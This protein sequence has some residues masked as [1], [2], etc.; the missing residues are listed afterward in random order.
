MTDFVSSRDRTARRSWFWQALGE[1]GSVRAAAVL[2]ATLI[3][4]VLLAGW[5]ERAYGGEAV[6]VMIYQARWFDALFLLLAMCVTAAAVVRF[7]WK[8]QQYGFV[9]VHVGLVMLIAGFW[10]AGHDRLDGMLEAAPGQ[11]AHRID[12]PLDQLVVLDQVE[13]SG[14]PTWASFRFISLCGLPSLP[15]FSLAW[16]W[17]IDEPGIRTLPKPMPVVRVGNKVDINIVR[18]VETGGEELAWG[19]SQGNS[20]SPAVELHL[21]ARTPG[22]QAD[23]GNRWLT[24]DPRGESVFTQ[25][26]LGATLTRTSSTTLV[27]DFLNEDKETAANGRLFVYHQG[28]RKVMT[29]ETLPMTLDL[30]PEL[31]ITA[32]RIIVHPKNTGEALVEDSAQPVHPV[33]ELTIRTGTGASAITSTAFASAYHLLPPLGTDGKLPEFLYRH[34]QLFTPAAGGSGAFVQLLVGP[35]ER[36][37]LRSWSRSAGPVART[38]ISPGTWKGVIAGGKTQAMEMSAGITWIPRAEQTPTV[39]EM[40]PDKKNHAVRW[41]ECEAVGPAGRIRAWLPRGGRQALSV[42]GYGELLISFQKAQLDLRKERG[43]AVRLDRFIEGKD[44]GG[45]MSAS[46]ASEVTVLEKD[47][48]PYQAT[49]SMN[50]PLHVGGVT[51]YQT[52][53]FPET[54]E[55]GRPTGRQVSVFTAAEDPGRTLKYLG[56]VVLVLGMLILWWLRPKATR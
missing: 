11:D 22:G 6:Q 43:F 46:Y 36:L 39:L 54:G 25:G 42:P 51:L 15:R 33:V 38:T 1:V 40:R 3:L 47:K 9:I 4:V 32:T 28:A 10:M 35:D 53:F 56:S 52:Q 55:D 26:P 34:P 48:P 16:L 2:I 18:V 37:H 29:L 21:S 20:G 41:L 27:E 12:L 7:P 45:M 14:A 13:G 44:P 19:E 49:V 50:E 30:G 23:M 17:P 5:Y 8:R 24:T 31:A